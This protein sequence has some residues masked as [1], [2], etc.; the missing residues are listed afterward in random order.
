MA[1]LLLRCTRFPPANPFGSTVEYLNIEAQYD[2]WPSGFNRLQELQITFWSSVLDGTNETDFTR[3]TDFTRILLHVQSAHLKRLSISLRT[4][5]S[6]H[7]SRAQV[8]DSL[9][10]HAMQQVLSSFEQLVHFQV[11]LCDNNEDFNAAWWTNQLRVSL[12][13]TKAIVA[14]EVTV[15]TKMKALWRQGVPIATGRLSNRPQ[16]FYRL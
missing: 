9:V 5:R 16:H 12:P 6:Y 2:C 8:M 3:D 1:P 13:M 7:R 4:E 11:L 15:K 10:G 14:C